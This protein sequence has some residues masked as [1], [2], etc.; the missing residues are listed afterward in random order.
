MNTE[1]LTITI[2]IASVFRQQAQQFA[3]E[4][5]A[6]QKK[7]RVDRNTLAV[8]A[9]VEYLQW[10]GYDVQLENSHCWNPV[11][12]TLSDVA[13]VFVGNVGR[14]EC[15]V[16]KPLAQTCEIP[17]E[18]QQ[19]RIGYM[20][21]NVEEKQVRLL[22]F[23]PMFDPEDVPD[24]VALDEL[25]SLDGMVDYFD[26]LERGAAQL[27]DLEPE[28][29]NRRLMRVA[30]L[31]RIYRQEKPNRWGIKAERVLSGCQGELL[32]TKEA[33]SATDLVARQEEAAELMQRLV[34]VWET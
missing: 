31:E 24:E 7:E 27:N 19:G 18:A 13:D 17:P 29:E 30:M 20:V 9:V 8:L 11:T 33:D 15:L 32:M 6:S 26:R 3:A 10:Q 12:R 23:A 16:A 34:R 14:I 4:Q 22:G 5:T 28:D 1:D 21:T 2:A 25:E